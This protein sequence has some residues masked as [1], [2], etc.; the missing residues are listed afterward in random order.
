M[1]LVVRVVVVVIR[2][3]GKLG[4]VVEERKSLGRGC[5]H[6]KTDTNQGVSPLEG[7]LTLLRE[8]M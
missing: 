8:T 7:V 2:V 5:D 6:E 4:L 1:V 3:E